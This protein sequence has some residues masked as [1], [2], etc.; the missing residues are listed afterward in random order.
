MPSGL[1]RPT[2]STASPADAPVDELVDAGDEQSR[3]ENTPAAESRTP[4]PRARRKSVPAGGETK[5]RKLSLPDSVYDR[6]YLLAHMR[7]T[8]ASAIA[9]EILDRNLPRLRIEREG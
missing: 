7:K 3:G 5:G 4:K 9:A 1:F 2:T 6:L 8:T